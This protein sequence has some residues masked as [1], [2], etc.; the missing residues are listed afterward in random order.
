MLK[1]IATLA[2]S[3]SATSLALPTYYAKNTMLKSTPGISSRSTLL[4]DSVDPH[5]VWVLPPNAG[6]VK[7]TGMTPNGNL[8]FCPTVKKVVKRVEKMQD[9]LA[10]LDKRI[11]DATDELDQL[12]KVVQE[13]RLELAKHVKNQHIAEIA[14][15]ED[16]I[17]DLQGVINDLTEK[18]TNSDNPEEIDVLKSRIKQYRKERKEARKLAAKLRN[19]NRK[20]YRAYT[21]AKQELSAAEENLATHNDHL[22]KL[23]ATYSEIE[24]GIFMSYKRYVKL[25]GVIASLDYDSGW[26]NELSKLRTEHP[27]LSFSAIPTYNSRVVSH[28]I[29]ATDKESYFESLPMLLSYNVNG[30]PHLP[31]GE[32]KEVADPDRG[33]HSFPEIVALD[34]RLNLLGGCPM[35]NPEFYAGTGY[36]VERGK[37]GVPKFALTTVY[38]YDAAYHFDVEAKYNLWGFYQKIV[39]KGKKGGFFSSKS[40]VDVLEDKF[41]KDTFDFKIVNEGHVPAKEVKNIKTEIKA[42]LM[43]RVLTAIAEPKTKNSPKVPTPGTPPEPGAVVIANGLNKVCGLNIYCQVGSWV[44]RAA[45]AVFGDQKTQTKIEKRWNVMA[46]EKWSTTSMVPRQAVVT[47][48]R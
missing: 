8:D 16:K 32:R 18:M 13:K 33:K 9:R 22:L 11:E 28:F 10:Q 30:I 5:R 12:N 3:I 24:D 47:Y 2:L 14:E 25:E 34:L 1:I 29:N 27:A 21:R 17:D 42:E 45:G 41:N 40:Y 26:D 4:A 38:E 23:Y 44:F 43:G 37:D 39:T 36:E 15:L 7:Y 6:K 48:K 35:A 20:S 19:E 31:Y 46:E